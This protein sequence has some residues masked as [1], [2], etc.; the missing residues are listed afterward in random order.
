M[1]SRTG[2]VVEAAEWAMGAERGREGLAEDDAEA[3]RDAVGVHEQDRETAE[4]VEA[5][6]EGHDHPGDLADAS[7]AADDHEPHQEGE[8]DTEGHGALRPVEEGQHRGHLRVRLVGLE[9]VAAADAAADAHQREHHGQGAA[10]ASPAP[11]GEA[12]LQVVHGPA[13][14]VP[15]GAH[16]PVHLAQRALCELRAHA[17]EASDDHPE[18]GSR[19]AQPDRYGDTRDVAEAYGGGERSGERLKV[20]D[21]ARIIGLRVA[22]AHARDGVAEGAQVDELEA[23]GEEQGAQDQPENHGWNLDAGVACGVPEPDVEEEHRRQRVD[24]PQAE[25]V[26]EVVHESDGLIHDGLPQGAGCA[27]LLLHRRRTRGA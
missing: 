1:P 22:A 14:H 26:L 3:R 9:H 5:A 8:H 13:G 15:V 18:D 25:V 23:Q 17:Q 16:H 20:G 21:L 2:S 19:P 6:H 10:R 11:F 7:D 24:D 27:H 4:H 12:V